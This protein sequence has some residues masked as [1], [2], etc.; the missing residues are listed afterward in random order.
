[1]KSGGKD[2]YLFYSDKFKL[3]VLLYQGT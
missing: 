3:A 1:V 2:I